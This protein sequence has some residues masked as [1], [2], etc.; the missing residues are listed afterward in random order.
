MLLFDNG[1]KKQPELNYLYKTK[2]LFIS[3]FIFQL[4][5]PFRYLLYPNELFWTEEGFRFSWRVMLMEKAGYATF[6]V[7][8]AVSK[9]NHN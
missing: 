4:V 3:C 9:R 6:K 1:K 2:M 5:F 8:D 7:R